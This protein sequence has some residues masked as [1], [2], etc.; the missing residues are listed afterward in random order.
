MNEVRAESPFAISSIAV[1]RS[2][3]LRP[4]EDNVVFS[5]AV[6]A[7][8]P[9]VDKWAVMDGIN[10]LVERE[11]LRVV[12]AVRKKALDIAKS[13]PEQIRKNIS[14]LRAQQAAFIASRMAKYPQ[15]ERRTPRRLSENEKLE[16]QK[17]DNQISAEE[18]NLGNAA[19]D[20]PLIEWEIARI[21]AAMRGED[22]PPRPPGF[23]E[24][25]TEMQPGIDAMIAGIK[26]GAG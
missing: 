7:T 21:E 23:E 24:A 11:R 1:Q 5:A 17:F 12:L 16:V 19:R 3:A 10:A 22:A 20:V 15:E 14:Q 4:N 18:L 2:V 8:A 9:D 26:A 13:Q 6:D 25:V